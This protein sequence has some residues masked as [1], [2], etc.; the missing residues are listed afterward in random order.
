MTPGAENWT[1]GLRDIAPRLSRIGSPIKRV[2]AL[3]S[4]VV[5]VLNEIAATPEAIRHLGLRYRQ[6]SRSATFDF[7]TF[8]ADPDP[9]AGAGDEDGL[10]ILMHRIRCDRRSV[11]LI[12]NIHIAY[13]ARHAIG[14]LR[15]RQRNL[16]G[17]K[18]TAAFVLVGALGPFDPQQRGARRQ[19]AASA[20]RRRAAGRILEAGGEARLRRRGL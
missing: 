5:D 19:R 7:A 11:E 12:T 18:A 13:I 8:S 15:E 20:A 14:R 17:W 10:S 9:I 6:A 16:T 1:K 3:R 4:Q 2:A